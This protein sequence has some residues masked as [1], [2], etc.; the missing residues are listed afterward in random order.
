MAVCDRC[1]Q[2]NKSLSVFPNEYMLQLISTILTNH[3]S[4]YLKINEEH[5]NGE[6]VNVLCYKNTVS[7]LTCRVSFP[8]LGNYERIHK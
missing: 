3:K 1:I 6:F 7:L 5:Y 8:L 2:Q 4:V